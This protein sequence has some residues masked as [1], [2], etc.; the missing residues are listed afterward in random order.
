MLVLVQFLLRLPLLPPYCVRMVH[1][2]IV[3]PSQQLRQF[4][5]LEVTVVCCATQW[6]PSLIFPPHQVLL[7]DQ[8]QFFVDPHTAYVFPASFRMVTHRH[9]SIY[10]LASHLAENYQDLE[11]SASESDVPVPSQPQHQY[12]YVHQS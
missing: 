1:A 4:Q 10:M 5:L 2:M 9:T 8:A 11:V 7:H 6:S 3:F 12:R